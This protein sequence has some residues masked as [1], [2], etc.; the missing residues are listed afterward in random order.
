[1]IRIFGAFWFMGTGLPVRTNGKKEAVVVKTPPAM[2][3]S[4][5]I[6]ISL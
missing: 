3:R 4:L 1:M 2:N 5:T 6:F